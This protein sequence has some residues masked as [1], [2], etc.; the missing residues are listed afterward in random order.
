[1]AVHSAA[2]TAIAC[3]HCDYFCTGGTH[4]AHVTHVSMSPNRPVSPKAL[5]LFIPP[6][7]H[8]CPP[9]HDS[10]SSRQTRCQCWVLTGLR[11]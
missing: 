7:S 6:M 3:T 11:S 8:V 1:M 4:V 9:G 5:M 10:S 2:H